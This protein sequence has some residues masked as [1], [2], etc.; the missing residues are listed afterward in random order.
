MISKELSALLRSRFGTQLLQEQPH[1]VIAPAS[2]HFVQDAANIARREHL[3][4]L[5]LGTGNS[6]PTDY[7]RLSENT[8]AILMGTLKGE[9]G[10]DAFSTW[11]WAGTRLQQLEVDYPG[12]FTI[13]GGRTTI[14]GLIADNASSSLGP[15]QRSIKRLLLSMEVLTAAGDVEI[16]AG[17]GTGTVYHLPTSSLFFGSQGRL[18]ILLRM[19]LRRILPPLADRTEMLDSADRTSTASM[20]KPVLPRTQMK[21]L[22]DPG[23]LFDWGRNRS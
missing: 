3:K 18:G 14:G 20:N 11:Y 8:I 16:F 7:S 9:C 19:R 23:G 1:I 17:E 4:L 5:P 2:I 10:G 13:E 22:L 6:F 15:I 21:A 12:F